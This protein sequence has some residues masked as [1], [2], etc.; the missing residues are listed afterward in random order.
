MSSR[1][2]DGFERVFTFVLYCLVHAPLP[3]TK[4][5][6]AWPHGTA[7][8]RPKRVRAFLG[9]RLSPIA[10]PALRIAALSILTITAPLQAQSNQDLVVL[11]PSAESTAPHPEPPVEGDEPEKDSKA[12]EQPILSDDLSIECNRTVYYKNKLEFSL[13]GGWLPIN[14]PF[15][16]DFLFGSGY[17]FPGLY[18]TLVPIVASVRWHVDDVGGPLILRGNWDVTA[19][20]SVTLIPR[21]AETRYFSYMMG[22]RRNFVP[23]RWRVAPYLDGE[24]GFG[25]I[26]AKGPLGVQYAQGQNFT[27]TLNLGSGIRYNFNPRYALEGGMH[28]MHISNL[29]LSEPKFLNYGINVY[30]PWVGIDIRLGKSRRA[31]Q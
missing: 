21:G 22:I 17:N 23:R 31:P 30:G 27:F 20:G 15:P 29:Y 14:I 28:Y 19:S 6:L 2:G 9:R 1:F 7:F 13:E 11:L 12:A 4:H 16:F 26:D 3:T 24:V 8:S 5:G 18:Y 10:E 25:Q